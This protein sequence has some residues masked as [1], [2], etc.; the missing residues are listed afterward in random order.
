MEGRVAA[1]DVGGKVRVQTCSMNA[2][3]RVHR[4]ERRRS[5][6]ND[7]AR[8]MRHDRIQP[9][10]LRVRKEPAWRPHGAQLALPGTRVR[11]AGECVLEETVVEA[12]VVRHRHSLRRRSW[13]SRQRKGRGGGP[14]HRVR[15]TSATPGSRAGW[16]TS[17]SA[18]RAPLRGRAARHRAAGRARCPPSGRSAGGVGA[19]GLEVDD[20]RRGEKL[21]GT[22]EG[23]RPRLRSPRKAGNAS[24]A[25]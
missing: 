10:D 3:R 7:E 15:E 24:Q 23:P 16:V 12:R 17:G 2:T 5:L 18:R 21:H 1:G 14:H 22:L 19:G 8:E 25:P 6:S 9:V 11:C 20:E 4:R 13:E